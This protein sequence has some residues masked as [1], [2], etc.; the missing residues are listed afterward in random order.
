MSS[1][2]DLYLLSEQIPARPTT[3]LYTLSPSAE[4]RQEQTLGDDMLLLVLIKL[5]AKRSPSVISSYVVAGDC[6]S[7][8]V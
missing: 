4:V 5:G 2:L 8:E 3:A 1:D 6:P 7:V